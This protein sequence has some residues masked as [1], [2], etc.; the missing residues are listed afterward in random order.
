MGVR[1]LRDEKH[2]WGAKAVRNPREKHTPTQIGSVSMMSHTAS[3]QIFG[4]HPVTFCGLWY[5]IAPNGCQTRQKL[6]SL[7]TALPIE[8]G[9]NS[10]NQFYLNGSVNKF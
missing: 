10:K 3:W 8:A 7:K 5:P 9:D 1:L 2:N 6:K 4:A